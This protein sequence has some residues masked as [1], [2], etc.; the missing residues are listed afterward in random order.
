MGNCIVQCL[1]VA[2][3]LAVRRLSVSS[4][5]DKHIKAVE[6]NNFVLDIEKELGW[7]ALPSLMG[8]G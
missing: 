5:R 1:W 3:I 6:I 2:G 8:L 4:K 7:P